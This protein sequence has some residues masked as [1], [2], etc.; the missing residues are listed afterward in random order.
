MSTTN[1]RCRHSAKEESL[2]CGFPNMI[3]GIRLLRS[4]SKKLSREV[5]SPSLSSSHFMSSPAPSHAG[6]IPG[7]A[8]S[9]T[10]AQRSEGGKP[11]FY[12]HIIVGGGPVGTGT[13]WYLGEKTCE[14]EVPE[15]VLLVHDP[16]N[17]GAHEDWSR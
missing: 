8:Y 11:E 1:R 2:P 7:R 10:P 16:K 4:Q 5:V 3:T 13:A 14:Q 15:K 12:D 6:S 17:P 9:S